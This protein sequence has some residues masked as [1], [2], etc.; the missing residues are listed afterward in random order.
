MSRLDKAR[1][2]DGGTPTSALRD[3]MQ[4]VMQSHAAVFR[5]GE[6]LDEGVKQM[7][8]V[9]A[10]RADIKVVDRSMIWNSDLVETLE[11]RNLLA[12]AMVTMYSAENRKESRG[13]HARDDFVKEMMKTGCVIRCITPRTNVLANGM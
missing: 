13:A 7:G 11:L 8:N 1:H 2:A 3:E 9:W 10:K 12:N 5:T 6:V 4:H